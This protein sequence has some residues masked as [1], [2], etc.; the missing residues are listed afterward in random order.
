MTQSNTQSGPI[1]L[2][3]SEALAANRLVGIVS[4]SGLPAAALPNTKTDETPFVTEE[5]VASG[6][7]ANLIPLHPAQNVR[8]TLSG[9]CVPGDL[10]ALA[11]P[12]GTVDGMVV[13]LPTAA[14][15]YR[16]I[17]IAEESGANGQAV[18]LRPVGQRLIT[19]T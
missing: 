6:E 9:T 12:N 14:G 10:L 17:G 11:T 5:A 13:K 16:L 18:L 19:V 1:P 15:T 7:R 4:A 2:T 8:A 3:A